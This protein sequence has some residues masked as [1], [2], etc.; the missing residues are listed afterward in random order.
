V[1]RREFSLI[2]LRYDVNRL[3]GVPT[4]ITPGLL[5]AVREHYDVAERNVLFLYRPKAG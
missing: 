4:D 2:A 3:R 1:Q 5:A